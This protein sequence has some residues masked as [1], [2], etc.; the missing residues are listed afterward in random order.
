M[1]TWNYLEDKQIRT[2]L[3]VMVLFFLSCGFCTTILNF[4][5]K[6]FPG[7]IYWNCMLSAI[8]DIIGIS[9]CSVVF[10]RIGSL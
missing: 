3:F 2:N 9:I 1:T 8:S 5:V 4:S 10:A 7:N 6:Y